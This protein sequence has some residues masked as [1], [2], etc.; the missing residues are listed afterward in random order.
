[1]HR[2]WRRSRCNDDGRTFTPDEEIEGRDTVIMLGHVRT[3]CGSAAK[4]K[5]TRTSLLPA[6]AR[7]LQ[8]IGMA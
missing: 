4:P 5:A 6:T 2:W 7:E 8:F 1:M 3:L